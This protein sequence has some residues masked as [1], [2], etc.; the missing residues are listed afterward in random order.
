[1]VNLS[2]T[3]SKCFLFSNSVINLVLSQTYCTLTGYYSK[4][5]ISVVVLLELFCL[6]ELY[7]EAESLKSQEKD[8]LDNSKIVLLFLEECSPESSSALSKKLDQL[9]QSYQR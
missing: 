7:T 5:Y 2:E 3:L 1:M 8:V 6:Q 9:T 4:Y